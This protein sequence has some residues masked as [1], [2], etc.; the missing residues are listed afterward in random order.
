MYSTQLLENTPVSFCIPEAMF[1][2]LSVIP[3]LFCNYSA[4][5]C[6]NIFYYPELC[7][8]NLGGS[9]F[10]TLLKAKQSRAQKNLNIKPLLLQVH[11]CWLLGCA[12]IT[13][14]DFSQFGKFLVH[15]IYP[16]VSP[17][18]A[19]PLLK[20]GIIKDYFLVSSELV[21]VYSI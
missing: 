16:V 19:Q 17:H 3:Q 1:V 10:L 4:I 2:G 13:T 15:K 6:H 5:G 18:S 11:Q 9:R 8:A 21:L 14:L 7:S 20:L 12:Q